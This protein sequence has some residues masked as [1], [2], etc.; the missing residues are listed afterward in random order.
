MNILL[1]TSE[2]V[3]FAKTGGLADVCGGG[4]PIELAKLGHHPA[5]ILP[6]YRQA[7]YCGQ[8]IEPLGIEFIVPIGSKM[9]TGHLLQSTLPGGDVPVYLVAAGPILRS[10][11]ALP[12]RRQGLHRQLRA[13]RVLLPRGDGG[14]PAVGPAAST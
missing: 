3:P 13:V 4:L 6:L 7:R 14:D 12:G 5:V 1:A 8:P 10:R 11:A 9:V 2:A